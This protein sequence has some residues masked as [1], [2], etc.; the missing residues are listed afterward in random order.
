[1]RYLAGDLV[2]VVTVHELGRYG[3]RDQLSSVVVVFL[4]VA[5]LQDEK[6]RWDEEHILNRMNSLIRVLTAAYIA[7]VLLVHLDLLDVRSVIS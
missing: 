4:L 6:R 1:M 2:D 5:Q 3:H 7:E